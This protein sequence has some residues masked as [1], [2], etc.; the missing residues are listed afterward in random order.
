MSLN[1]QQQ[2]SYWGAEQLTEEQKIYAA[3]DVLYLSLLKE[4]LTLMLQRERK[5]ALAKTCFEFLAT[6]SM[7]DVL[8]WEKVD[9][10]SHSLP[11]D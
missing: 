6:R 11:Q 2:T 7:L 9:I 8:G 1:K 5:W 10:F 4:K 3:N